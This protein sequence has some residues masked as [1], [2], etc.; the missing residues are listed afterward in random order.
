MNEKYPARDGVPLHPQE[1]GYESD[2]TQYQENHHHA[3][4][5]SWMAKLAI[6]QT[7]RDL[8]TM[9]SPLPVDSHRELHARLSAPEVNI[10]K[11][12]EYVWQS[13]EQTEQLRY[14]SVK[15]FSYEDITPRR[16]QKIEREY[17][18]IKHML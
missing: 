14:G 1:L 17:Q 5:K 11:A 15:N 13:Y 18:R 10:Q 8:S 4:T 2:P 9:Q 3:F 7:L 6:T 16:M 12:Y